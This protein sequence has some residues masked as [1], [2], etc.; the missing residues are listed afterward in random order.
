MNRPSTSTESVARRVRETLGGDD[1]SGALVTATLVR[2][3][4]QRAARGSRRSGRGEGNLA[5][6]AVEGTVQAVGE[7][8][9]QEGA[10]V[11]EAVVGV[12]EG[13]GE[14]GTVTTPT[15]RDVVIGA[16]RG[17]GRIRTDVG[18]VGR[19]AVEGAILGAARAGLDIT[20]ATTAVVAGA[21]DTVASAGGDL[22]D[23][24]EG[25]MGG[26]LAG[27]ADTDADLA[28][29]TYEAASTL[30]AHAA[31]AERN[32]VKVTAVAVSAVVTAL[33]GIRG[34]G[35]RAEDMA[36]AAASGA[37]AAGYKVSRA[38]GESVRQSVLIRILQPGF[39]IPPDLEKRRSEFVERLRVELP[40]GP[41]AWR[42]TAFVRGVQILLSVG[43]IDL[44]ASM[45]YFV[46]LSFLPIVALSIMAVALLGQPD[47]IRDLLISTLGYY[48]PAQQVVIR[49]AVENLLQ[50]SL[51]VGLVA[52]VGLVMGAN[53]LVLAATRAVNRVFE[54]PAPKTVQ[55]TL[56]QVVVTT[57]VVLLFLVSLGVT[58]SLQVA[59]SFGEGISQSTVFVSSSLLLVL[60][61][62][63]TM[64]PAVFTVGV[65]AAAYLRMPTVRV[66][67]PDAAFG[68]LTAIV[69]FEVGKHA[70]FWFT[71]LASQRNAVYGP[72][73]SFVVVLMWAFV[74]GMI[75]LYGAALTRAAGEL[76]PMKLTSGQK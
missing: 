58:A 20:Q 28:N 34:T 23:V 42:G 68:A 70:F 48:F 71:S 63:S 47:T 52:L 44:A 64:L 26:V 66:R 31:S 62:L 65:F 74:A 69:I 8:C 4:A 6:E 1:S 53:G 13:T 45:A 21:V 72:I 59:I 38:H 17:S 30:I 5:R 24:A 60:G 57:L 16:I 22:R 37:V 2:A 3:A 12:L 61:I 36:A 18:G 25:V 49:D 54:T 39:A 15:L 56:T 19:D 40:K 9:G 32:I 73:A 75:F 43:G 50:G 41:A 76:R 33:R 35:V 51:A 55:V 7:V 14:V 27:V 10:F 29:A 67:W 46:I 11:R